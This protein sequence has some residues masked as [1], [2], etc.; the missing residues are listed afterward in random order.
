MPIAGESNFHTKS[1]I[2]LDFHELTDQDLTQYICVEIM[3][4]DSVHFN[5]YFAFFLIPLGSNFSCS[6]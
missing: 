4:T 5:K 6:T 3:R 2:L 1:S